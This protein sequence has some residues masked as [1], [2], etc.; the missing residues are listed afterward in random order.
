MEG[1]KSY[2]SVLLDFD[3][4]FSILEEKNQNDFNIIDIYK[5]DLYDIKN[6]SILL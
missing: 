4:R 3:K 2:M 6:I 1:E 5:Y